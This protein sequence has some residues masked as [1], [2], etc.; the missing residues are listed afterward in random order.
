[1]SHKKGRHLF[2]ET[3][4]AFPG[5]M[6]TFFCETTHIKFPPFP[7]EWNFIFFRKKIE[8]LMEEK[9]ICFGSF[10][11]LSLLILS[12]ILQIKSNKDNLI[13]GRRIRYKR[14]TY[15]GKRARI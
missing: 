4:R 9:Q 13:N 8:L 15:A 3:L 11:I 12:L 6:L 5:K 14:H 10:F 2:S 1:M 7:S